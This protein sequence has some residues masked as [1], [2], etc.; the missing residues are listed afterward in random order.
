MLTKLKRLYSTMGIFF[1]KNQ[2]LVNKVCIERGWKPSFDSDCRPSLEKN[3]A[4]L[5]CLLTFLIYWTSQFNTFR[6]IIIGHNV[7]CYPPVT[8]GRLPLPKTTAAASLQL[9]PLSPIWSGVRGCYSP[10]ICFPEICWIST[11]ILVHAGAFSRNL[12]IILLHVRVL[13]QFFYN[14]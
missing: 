6:L 4:Y 14:L 3:F 2:F 7:C 1:S 9:W 11:I 10:E 5:K 8:Q 12:M 13:L